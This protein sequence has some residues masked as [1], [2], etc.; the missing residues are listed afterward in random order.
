MRRLPTWN[1]IPRELLWSHRHT[2]G[3]PTGGERRLGL[4]ERCRLGSPDPPRTDRRTRLGPRSRSSARSY[5]ESLSGAQRSSSSSIP[6][7]LE[8]SRRCPGFGPHRRL[9]G[10]RG[11]GKRPLGS[12]GRADYRTAGGDGS[13]RSSSQACARAIHAASDDGPTGCNRRPRAR[14]TRL[15]SAARRS[16][17]TSFA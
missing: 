13:A 4:C 8:W 6:A 11:G 1:V 16:L 12:D 17:A 9:A 15:P 5:R 3:D 2:R 14:S 10:S 7:T